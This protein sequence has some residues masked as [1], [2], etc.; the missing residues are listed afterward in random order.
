MATVCK[1]ENLGF[2]DSLLPPCRV[3]PAFCDGRQGIAAA[4]AYPTTYGDGRHS[5]LTS[6][7]LPRL[8]FFYSWASHPHKCRDFPGPSFSDHR[9]SSN[10]VAGTFC[11]ESVWDLALP[12]GRQP[13][14]IRIR[15]QSSR[16]RSSRRLVRKGLFAAC[17]HMVSPLV[18]VSQSNDRPLLERQK[19]GEI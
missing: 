8:F 12:R 16:G 6:L 2:L 10:Q 17:R 15:R 4:I 9:I 3:G 18:L 19:A 13:Q 7:S 1:L 11:R 14:L 5:L